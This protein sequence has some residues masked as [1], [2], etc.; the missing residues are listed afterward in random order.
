MGAASKVSVMP[1]E[2]GAVRT[3]AEGGVFPAWSPDST[4]LVYRVGVAAT[5]REAA[6]FE[7][8]QLMTVAAGGGPARELT[9]IGSPPGGHNT[10][11]WLSDGRRVLFCA[12]LGDTIS[13]PWTA[14]VESGEIRRF[15]TV[16]ASVLHARLSPDGGWLYFSS[17][18]GLMRVRL[19]DGKPE[20][21][22]A[23]GAQ[24]PRDLAF[25]PDGKRLVFSQV[26]DQATLWRAPLDG[27]DGAGP[28]IDEVGVR[29][30]YPSFS[31]DG[32]YLAYSLLRRGARFSIQVLDTQGGL[33]KPLSPPDVAA[34]APSWTDAGDVGYMQLKAGGPEYWVQPLRSAGRLV[35]VNLNRRFI[36]R[37]KLSPD[38][39]WLA[40]IFM[41]PGRKPAIFITNAATGEARVI[42]PRDR[43]IAYPVWSYDSRWIAAEERLDG[44][45]ASRL[46]VL[47]REG[48][49]V[50]TLVSEKMHNWPG[51]VAADNDTIAFSG[52][53]DGI[54]NIYIVSR[55]TKKVTQVTR[56]TS[57]ALLVRYPALSRT[58]REVVF[59]YGEL[60]GN[61]YAAELK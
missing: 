33:S 24:M 57:R 41:E 32:R 53:R 40:G 28:F 56:F 55:K 8:T 47:P 19:P 14:D 43:D 36:R 5:A 20:T 35:P 23:A 39:K 52:M 58:K 18:S 34:L 17:L 15:A 30:T 11:V 16:P 3:L 37:V 2:G 10:P 45:P 61:V 46:V 31:R 25:S 27:Q 42:T 4:R 9:R 22:V 21:L 54:W 48:G 59:E 60:K 6:S 29:I 44:S 51:D 26:T 1:A 38:G 13:Q 50:E 7:A 12:S 49:T